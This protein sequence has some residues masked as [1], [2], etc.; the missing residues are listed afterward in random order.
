MAEYLY[1]TYIYHTTTDVIGVDPVV[2]AAKVA[3]FDTNYKSQCILVSDIIPAATTFDI[4]LGYLE[5]KAKVDGVNI[6]W[7]DI[8]Y[9]NEEKV[10][11]LYLI[12][13]API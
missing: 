1:H 6:L 9:A 8:K 12:T 2:E 13:N 5:F 10:Y 7:T 4:N 11:D 3:D